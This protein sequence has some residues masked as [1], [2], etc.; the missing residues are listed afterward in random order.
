MYRS[1]RTFLIRDCRRIAAKVHPVLV[2]TAPTVTVTVITTT[3]AI[4]VG[5]AAAIADGLLP[6]INVHFNFAASSRC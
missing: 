3:K 1:E 6:R 4:T 2:K 5:I